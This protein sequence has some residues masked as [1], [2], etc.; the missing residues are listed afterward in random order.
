MRLMGEDEPL[1][2]AAPTI[3]LSSPRPIIHPPSMTWPVLP[4][5]PR[6]T[7]VKLL[8]L[9]REHHH[10]HAT[11]VGRSHSA[12]YGGL[13]R[14]RPEE[15]ESLGVSAASALDKAVKHSRLAAM[16]GLVMS[17]HLATAVDK[18]MLAATAA[19]QEVNHSEGTPAAAQFPSNWYTTGIPAELQRRHLAPFDWSLP[20]PGPV[21][22]HLFV[23]NALMSSGD[24]LG[25]AMTYTLHN[26]VA[27]GKRDGSCMAFCFL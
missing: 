5:M 13:E 18:S 2:A 25:I 3:F 20:P 4:E 16:R 14:V 17:Q 24:A 10:H 7:P 26:F 6:L 21:G 15:L 22:S 23:N 1:H 27:R 12:H 9:P 19:N 8:P 11:H